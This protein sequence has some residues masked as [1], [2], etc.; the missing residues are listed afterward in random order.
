M[1]KIDNVNHPQHYKAPNGLEAIDVIEAFTSDMSGFEATHTG[2]ALK[3]L[4][5]WKHKNGLE[6]LK[7]ARWYIS[8][9]IEKLDPDEESKHEAGL[10][11]SE[12]ELRNLIKRNLAMEIYP[13][14]KPSIDFIYQI[15]EDAY[16]RKISYDVSDMKGDI[17]D[18]AVSSFSYADYCMERVREMK[19]VSE[20]RDCS[21]KEKFFFETEAEAIDALDYLKYILR[22]YR[23]IS[24]ADVADTL[25]AYCTYIDS[26]YGWTTLDGVYI[27][28]TN[29]GYYAIILPKRKEFKGEQ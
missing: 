8:R 5:R 13:A 4:L 3:Y 15:L 12:D 2:N 18:F 26:M 27:A 24:V 19:F 10:F 25:G 23:H 20:D 1:N 6:D 28:P 14:T 11:S 29:D 22:R 9:L 16:N 7:K 17:I 21:Q